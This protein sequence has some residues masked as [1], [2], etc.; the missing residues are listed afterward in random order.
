MSTC[1]VRTARRAA[2]PAPRLLIVPGLR[3]SGPVHWQTWLQ[4]LHP[5]SRRVTQHDWEDAVL[6][7]WALAIG[8]S[9]GEA[10]GGPWVVAAHSFGCLALLRY[11]MLEPEAPIASA[12][13]VAPADPHKF[14]VQDRLAAATTGADWSMVYSDTDPWL[15]ATAA[16][17]WATRWAVRA[18][19]LGAAGHINAEAGFGPW[20]W[21]QGWALQR[22]HAAT[23]LPHARAARPAVAAAAARHRRGSDAAASSKFA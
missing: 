8:R 12:V 14:G 7:R 13:L 15:S 11:R 22:L 9:L 19:S 10:P 5:T 6:D 18:R 17:Q 21:V 2:D 16:R 4:S 1:S 3:D 20:P 23:G